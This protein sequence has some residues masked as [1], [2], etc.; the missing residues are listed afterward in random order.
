[1]ILELPE[2]VVINDRT[3]EINTDYRVILN[4]LMATEDSNLTD[5]DK[6][7]VII[8]EFYTDEINAE[9]IEAALERFGWFVNLGKESPPHN[10]E[11]P[12]MDWD[13]DQDM[14]FSSIMAVAGHDVRND[15]YLHWW[16]FC[17]LLA[18]IDENSRLAGVM[19][20]R[21][22]LNRH[23]NLTDYE[24]EALN[25]HPELYAIKTAEQREIEKQDIEK[26]NKKIFGN[27][28]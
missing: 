5:R 20:I 13:Q 22:K 8:S 19:R 4:I 10:D 28:G 17:G 1:M 26:I 12:V 25:R 3:Y 2:S 9:D 23:E 15:D 27:K 18:E 24:K 7:Y 21:D 6:A 11:Q 16:T 14:I